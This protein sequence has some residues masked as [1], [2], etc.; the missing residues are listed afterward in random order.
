MRDGIPGQLESLY[1]QAKR[2]A[3]TRSKELCEAARGYATTFMKAEQIDLNAAAAR[4]HNA[5]LRVEL[6]RMRMNHAK[7]FSGISEGVALMTGMRCWLELHI[8]DDPAFTRKFG[9]RMKRAG[10]R[11]SSVRGSS[12]RR[13]IDA[14]M[15]WA[16]HLLADEI[17]AVFRPETVI[18]RWCRTSLRRKDL[19]FDRRRNS[20]DDICAQPSLAVRRT[21]SGFAAKGAPVPIPC[22]LE[23]A[24]E[25]AA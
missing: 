23:P 8:S 12:S 17:A 9:K 15:G 11:Y 14:P 18:L 16:G 6:S 5:E 7:G 13:Y 22:M 10:G 19:V 3:E 21:L 20:V 25:S 24:K 2:G 4:Y 1:W